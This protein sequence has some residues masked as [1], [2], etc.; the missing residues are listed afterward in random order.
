MPR[1]GPLR[2]GPAP[3]TGLGLPSPKARVLPPTRFPNG[4]Q[5][6]F[7]PPPRRDPPRFAGRGSP[8]GLHLV[9]RLRQGR[10]RAC[11]I[12]KA[13]P[14][15]TPPPP[16]L[17]PRAAPV[18]RACPEPRV[19][20]RSRLPTPQSS[21]TGSLPSRHCD[22]EIPTNPSASG[23]SGA[24]GVSRPSRTS[25]ASGPLPPSGLPGGSGGGPARNLQVAPG[26]PPRPIVDP[27]M[28]P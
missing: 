6:A 4:P 1:S 20:T 27:R 3:P 26:V 24:Y 14:P 10:F 7:S 21:G 17:R 5:E 22:R 23:I 19:L 18:F 13:K 28:P 2:P 16:G 8:T 12:L 15:R 9:Q 11:L 25:A